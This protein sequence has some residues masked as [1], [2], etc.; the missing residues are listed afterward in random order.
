MP[1]RLS[2]ANL[3][4]LGTNLPAHAR[5]LVADVIELHRAQIIR[6]FAEFPDHL[7]FTEVGVV[8]SITP[9][10]RIRAPANRIT[11][12][13]GRCQRLPV[14]RNNDRRSLLAS[15]AVTP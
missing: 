15:N 5:D 6:H 11:G 2:I 13:G 8:A 10:I 7:G 1:A 3:A 4:L 14:W 9:V 12:P